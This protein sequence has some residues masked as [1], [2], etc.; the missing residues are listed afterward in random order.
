AI[1]GCQRGMQCGRSASAVGEAATSA[2]VTAIVFIIVSDA[3]LTVIYDVL[4]I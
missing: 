3:M 4:H 2:V 1:A